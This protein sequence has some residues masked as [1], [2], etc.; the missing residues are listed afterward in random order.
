MIRTAQFTGIV[1]YMGA[2][3][4]EE[5]EEEGRSSCSSTTTRD[6]GIKATRDDD[7]LGVREDM[8]TS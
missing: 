7:D 1:A 4:L 6:A 3:A 8:L 5:V 2:R